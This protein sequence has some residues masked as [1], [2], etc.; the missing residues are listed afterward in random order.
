[1]AETMTGVQREA[2]R[3]ISAQRW[4]ALAT[5][6]GD[7]A[8]AVSYVPFAPL[9]GSFAIVVS[10]L[11]AHTASLLAGRPASVMV[12][13]ADATLEDS[14]ARRR[15]SIGVIAK[16][17]AP[18]ST[19]ANAVWSALETH[20]GETAAILRTLPDFEAVTLAPLGGRLILGFAAAHDV[21]AAAIE[22]MLR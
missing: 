8:P 22:G 21:S 9:D 15:F 10:R 2:A 19:R 16:P 18:G 11:A 1:M 13:D 17:H 20:Q 4:L 7:G 5:L 12:V 6:D 14:F 3:L